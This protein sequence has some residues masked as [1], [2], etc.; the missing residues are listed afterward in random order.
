MLTLAGGA[1][2]GQQTDFQHSI[3]KTDTIK[4]QYV[5]PLAV[6]SARRTGLS[7][8]PWGEVH[9][10]SQIQTADGEL[11]QSRNLLS[12]PA[13]DQYIKGFG[14]FCKKEMQIEKSLKLPLRFRLGSLEQ[15]NILEQKY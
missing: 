14:F 12:A 7:V 2:Y 11:T 3:P 4:N 8:K 5:S 1:V 9:R 13:K 15:C 10:I 6:F